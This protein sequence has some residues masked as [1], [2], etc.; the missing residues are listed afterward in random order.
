MKKLSQVLTISFML[1]MAFQTVNVIGQERE[2]V[3]T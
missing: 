1:L 2:G 3:G